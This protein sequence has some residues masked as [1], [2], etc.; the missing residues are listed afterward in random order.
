M[1]KGKG[2]RAKNA[3]NKEVDL[4]KWFIVDLEKKIAITGNEYKEDAIDALSDYDGDKNFKIVSKSQL[5]KLG[6]DDPTS[7][8]KYAKGGW[9]KDHNYVNKS[10]NYE[11]RYSKDK[12]HRS[13]YKKFAGGGEIEGKIED[14]QAVVDGDFPQ[15]A[16]DKAKSEIERLTKELHESKE[17]KSEDK[18]EEKSDSDIKKHIDSLKLSKFVQDA[19]YILSADEEKIEY[20]SEDKEG[21]DK[22]TKQVIEAINNADEKTRNIYLEELGF[23]S[24][25]S[26]SEEKAD[27]I[28]K[29]EEIS[30]EEKNAIEHSFLESKGYEKFVLGIYGDDSVDNAFQGTQA[31]KGRLKSDMSFGLAYFHTDDYSGV[32]VID[33]DLMEWIA[34][35]FSN[36]PIT[37]YTNSGFDLHSSSKNKFK[38]ITFKKVSYSDFLKFKDTSYKESKTS[39]TEEKIT[40]AKKGRKPRVSKPK[41]VKGD[42]PKSK[43]EIGD[44]VGVSGHNEVYIISD[45]SYRNN[46]DNELTWVYYLPEYSSVLVSEKNLKTPKKVSHKDVLA[47]VKAKKGKGNNNRGDLVNYKT[48]DDKRRTRSV[49]SDKKREAK[50]LGRRVSESGNIYY[51]NRLNRADIDKSERYKSGGEI[52]SN[53]FRTKRGCW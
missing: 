41:E 52:E 50:P 23:K 39:E 46:I 45:K 3:Y 37:V 25:E 43:Y 26:K 10:E 34:D 40:P 28:S 14:L 16:K 48:G 8:W 15:F 1:I 13:G 53:P 47:K 5:K 38:N 31:Q 7:E 29:S 27:K 44:K 42:L 18:A 51:E 2:S 22:I 21:R 11:T 33:E 49:S 19:S 32:S 30:A 36:F 35:G 6:V 24:K 17:L 12:A 4:Y 20:R 9:L